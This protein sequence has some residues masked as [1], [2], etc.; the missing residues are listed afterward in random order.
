[1][2]VEI[3][4]YPLELDG[5]PVVFHSARD[6]SARRKSEEEVRKL[7]F[8]DPLTE[9]PNRRLLIQRLGE[10]L[11]ESTGTRVKGALLFIDLDN[12]KTVNDTAGHY[13]G[14]RLLVRVARTLVECV[15]RNDVVARIGGDEFVVLLARLGTDEG[16][17]TRLADEVAR[18][19]LNTLA[20]SLGSG[21]GEYRASASIGVT[22]FDG[23]GEESAEAPLV[24]ADVA[25][26]AAKLA[27]R[28]T[29]RFFD[30]RM[31]AALS[32]R[33]EL[34]TGLWTALEQRQFF[35]SYQAQVLASGEVIGLEAL[36]RWRHPQRG[37]VSPASFIPL[38]EETGL[39]VQIGRWVLETACMQLARWAAEPARAGLPIS[40]NVSARQ[41]LDDRFVD[42]VLEVLAR[43]GADPGRLKLELTESSLLVDVEAVIGK[44]N[45]LK[46]RGIGFSLDDFGTG[47]SSLAYLKRLPLEQLKI[48]QSFVRDILDD[49]NDAEIARLVIM[50]AASL[51]LVVVAEG[52]ET[53][54]QREY[55]AGLGCE[56]YQGYLFAR[57][58]P[59]AELEAF[60]AERDTV[61]AVAAGRCAG[62]EVA[63][64]GGR[65]ALRAASTASSR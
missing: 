40:V 14:D 13:E 38:A 12:F 55:L 24:R 60:L 59:I 37:L 23:E 56:R 62:P 18:R 6:I 25:M 34:E 51:G 15:S 7:A 5:R 16:T 43:T 10:T 53:E 9:L 31:Q 20:T 22:L 27:G 61:A 49:A 39:I 1:M 17:V 32:E 21:D 48:D 50:L 2:P 63:R 57:P 33:A 19:I 58:L 42:D 4:S 36:L 35:L 44:M 54:A 64:A 47:Y 8:F 11:S 26:F 30:P 52:V 28:N 41:I 65:P 29:I 3:T 46:A 45:M